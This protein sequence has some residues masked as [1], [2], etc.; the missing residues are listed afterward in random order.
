M[1]ETAT[2]PPAAPATTQTAQPAAATQDTTDY[3]TKYMEAQRAAE[4]QKKEKIVERRQW[5]SER[6]TLG[7][8]LSRLDELE[9]LEKIAKTNPEAYF[10]AKYGD[11]WYDVATNV[12]LNGTP[13][14]ELVASKLEEMEA[15]IESKLS[16][17]DE[18]LKKEREAAQAAQAAEGE[19]QVQAQWAQGV[20]AEKYPALVARFGSA[21][22]VAQ[23]LYHSAKQTY[24]NTV[25]YAEDGS[26]LEQGK[27][28]PFG[29]LAD[30]FE[31]RERKYVTELHP[32]LTPAPNAGSTPPPKSSQ[33]SP[34]QP[35]KSQRVT[36]SN[37]ITAS[38][39][40][41]NQPRVISREEKLKAAQ[42][43]YAE[44]AGRSKP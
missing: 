44:V 12:R 41:S 38:S 26:L 6:K 17:R 29:E 31:A 28:R 16:A 43:K 8:K 1:S 39:T 24:L 25:K 18:A 33:Q 42:A 3:R 30:E 9:K 20:T 27:V 34:S 13:P 35:N 36:L 37:S 11:G 4:I 2:T 10:K 22:A 5:E 40:G 23:A 32:R 7:E 15:K 21:Q 19:R 14:A